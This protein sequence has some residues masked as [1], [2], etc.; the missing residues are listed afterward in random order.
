MK[1][2]HIGTSGIPEMTPKPTTLN[3]IRHLPTVGLDAMELEF[4]HSV[5]I[6]SEVA[7][8]VKQAAR[9]SGVA[10]TCHGQ[11]Y[12]NLA[13]TDNAKR[14]ASIQRVLTA[15]RRAH[16]CGAWS[17]TFHGGF[18]LGRD[19]PTTTAIIADA[20][21]SI[22]QMLNDEGIDI[23][24]RPEI[25]GKISQWGNLQELVDISRKFDRV[26]PC[27]DFSHLY[28][29]TVGKENGYESAAHTLSVIEQSFG[30]DALDS[31]HMHASGIVYTQKGEKNHTLLQD[32]QFDYEG[33]LKALKEFSVKGSLICESPQ[34]QRDAVLL[35]DT[36]KHLV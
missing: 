26:L 12:I 13:A 17:M 21:S 31:M 5:N 34:P 18:Y 6:K 4:V 25:S 23:W 11:Y 2:L 9:E 15:A 7:P 29:R 33:M 32:S 8:L 16:E 10:L 28:A 36:L 20:F 3:G 22:M 27:I 19:S 14:D 35:R 24:V 1:R 30:R